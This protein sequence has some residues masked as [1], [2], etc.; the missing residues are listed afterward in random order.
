MNQNSQT[1]ILPPLANRL[2]GF[3][4]HAF[5]RHGEDVTLIFDVLS[6]NEGLEIKT[7]NIT[8][9]ISIIKEALEEVN[10]RAD[11][12]TFHLNIDEAENPKNPDLTITKFINDAQEGE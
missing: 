8:K 5:Q 11:T 3:L 2:F 9:S 4:T 10:L 1:N 7:K 12:Y 6:L